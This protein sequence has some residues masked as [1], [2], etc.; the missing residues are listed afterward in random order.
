MGTQHGN[1]KTRR[2]LLAKAGAWLGLQPGA[3]IKKFT[4][5]TEPGPSPRAGAPGTIVGVIARGLVRWTRSEL[6]CRA[7]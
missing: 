4:A 3:N 5:L 1:V 2:A 6:C 7:R